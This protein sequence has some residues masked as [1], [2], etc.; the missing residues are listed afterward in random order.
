M[1]EELKTT[2][3][4]HDSSSEVASS[5]SANNLPATAAGIYCY[6]LWY[7]AVVLYDMHAIKQMA[8]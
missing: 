7:T 2:G 3:E 1:H 4:L 8:W 5:C 6:R